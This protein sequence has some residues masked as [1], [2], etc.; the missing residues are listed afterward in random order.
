MIEVRIR[1]E[2]EYAS[3]HLTDVP[4]DSLDTIIPTLSAWGV[5]DGGGEFYG[6]FVIPSSRNAYFEIVVT[7][8]QP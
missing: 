1:K 3:R 6:Q 4:L 7:Q 2:D 8:E 5:A